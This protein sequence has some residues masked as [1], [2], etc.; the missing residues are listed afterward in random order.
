MKNFTSYITKRLTKVLPFFLMVFSLPIQAEDIIYPTPQLCQT[1]YTDL[2]DHPNPSK[3]Y[4]E[5]WTYHL[6][7]NSKIQVLLNYSRANVGGIKDPVCGSDLSIIGFKSKNYSVAREY[8]KANF[9][10]NDSVQ[11]LN[12]HENIWFKGHLPQN[13]QTYLYT[14]KNGIR[15]LVDLHYSDIAPG[16]TMGSGQFKLG[17]QNVGIFIHIPR[18]RVKGIIAVNDDTLKVEGTAYMDHTFQTTMGPDL[19]EW[20]FRYQRLGA[21]AHVSY[22]IQTPKKYGHKLIGF[23]LKETDQ[24]WQ[25]LNPISLVV[26][27]R[28]KARSIKVPTDMTIKYEGTSDHLERSGD[29]QRLSVLNEFSG[30]TKWAVKNFMGGEIIY[31]R[32]RGLLNGAPANYNIFGIQD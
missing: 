6:N 23:G 9:K 25:L 31:F 7:L 18:A 27:A 4:N 19:A 20:G 11:G 17:E 14:V 10:F 8:P 15:Y 22:I 30:L 16:Y 13:H 2:K 1:S 29:S 21:K 28:K 24:G 12:V 3:T 26:S 32:G 5:F